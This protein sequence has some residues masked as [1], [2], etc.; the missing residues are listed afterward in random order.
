VAVQ[1]FTLGIPC[2]YYGTEQALGGPEASERHWLPGWKASDR[3]LREA[4]FGPDH[5][6]QP[7]RAGLAAAPAG[8]DETLPGFGPFGTRGR[9]AFDPDSGAYRRIAA[10]AA[11]RRAYPVLRY[12]RQYPR[13]TSFLDRPFNVWGPGEIVAWSRILD[14]EEAL[15]AI[16]AHGTESRGADVVVD[17]DLTPAGSLMTV[18]AS[19]AGIA[20]TAPGTLAVGSTLVVQRS[21]SG[22]AFVSLRDAPPSEVV[23]LVNHG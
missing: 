12:G 5:P 6:R 11:V 13:P 18:V 22:P 14:D 1:L 17:A 3:Y 8:A 16:N 19:T 15:C 23:V 7:G 20:G 2:I 21:G 10:L 9:H 4:L